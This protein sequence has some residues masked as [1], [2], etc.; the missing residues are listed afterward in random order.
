MTGNYDDIDYV[1]KIMSMYIQMLPLISFYVF[2]MKIENCGLLLP[3]FQFNAWC[4]YNIILH[5]V[6]LISWS[7]EILIILATIYVSW[8][9]HSA[10]QNFQNQKNCELARSDATPQE[11]GNVAVRWICIAWELVSGN[12]SHKVL[13]G[14]KFSLLVTPLIYFRSFT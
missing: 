8:N 3:S 7:L 6:F 11:I 4:M 5:I 1:Q 13:F 14:P 10:N 9:F 12:R 2:L